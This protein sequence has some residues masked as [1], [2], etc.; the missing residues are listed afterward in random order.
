MKRHHVHFHF[1]VEPA[2]FASESSSGRPTHRGVFVSAVRRGDPSP[3]VERS[4]TCALTGCRTRRVVLSICRFCRPRALV[5]AACYEAS[6][7][8]IRAR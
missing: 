8:K 6:R 4:V 3:R 7:R 1:S 2:S 5:A